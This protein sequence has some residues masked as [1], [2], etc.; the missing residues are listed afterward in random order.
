MAGPGLVPLVAA[1]LGAGLNAGFFYAFAHDVMPALRQADDADF[2]RGFR[3]LD[4]RVY[5]PFFMVVFLGT[6]VLAAV[7]VLLL[8][9]SSATAPLLWAVAALV[10]ALGT[11]AITGTV[12]VPMNGRLQALGPVERIT[13]LYLVRGE[14]EQRWV[15]WNLVRTGTSVASFACLVGALAV[16]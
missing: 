5:N 6:P 11:V 15:R 7:T 12:H 14:F 13:G 4:R 1:T 3:A 8:A 10:L 16:L 9:V 2:V